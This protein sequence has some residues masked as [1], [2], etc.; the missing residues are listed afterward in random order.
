M[1]TV[2]EALAGALREAGVQTVFGLPGGENVEVLDALRR[3]GIAFVLVH[4]EPSAVF[5]ADT[6]ARL[7]GIPGVCLTTLGPG[8]MNAVA[9]V[10]H[11]YLDRAPVLV[12]TATAPE[13]VTRRHTHQIVDI[14]AVYRPITKASFTLGVKGARET[15][16]LA[17]A[18]T[19]RGRP[20]PVH[21]QVSGE[22]AAQAAEP[23]TPP[24]VGPVVGEPDTAEGMG[25]AIGEARAILRQ[26]RKPV[27]V[28]GLGLEPE[29]PYDGLRVLAESLNAPVIVTPKAKGAIPDDH[30][31]AAG[32]I[33]LTAT[34]P[35]YEILDD[36]DCVVAVAFDVVE[37]VK[38]WAH[39]APLIWIAPWANEDP[40][41]PTAVEIVGP[42][43]PVL[44]KLADGA[45]TVDR[46]WG[47]Q[48]LRIYKQ[49]LARRPL[50]TPKPGTVLP[51]TVVAVARDML[52]RDAVVTTDVGSHKIFMC[53]EWPTLAPNR[54]FVSNGLSVMGFAVPAAIAAARLSPDR[55][56]MAVTGDGGMLMAMG[57][58][59]LLRT[60]QA[61]VLI[62]VMRDDALD[63]IRSKQRRTGKPVYGT[64]FVG[65]D[66]VEA[67][68][69]FGL[70]GYR[71]RNEADLEA[72]F[73]QA[74]KAARPAV[75][76][77]FVD[78][79]GYPTTPRERTP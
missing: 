43:E 33:G 65:P 50:P 21:V 69:A 42:V 28:V 62:V 19:T 53:L 35:V 37:L 24:A 31:L 34:D 8:A 10:A 38:P 71:V 5:M 77:V 16:E 14:G 44:Y 23:G 6:T 9:G 47:A 56:V 1:P 26:A 15:V 12:V 64:E 27:I 2:A 40:R 39:D 30:P 13:H 58:L 51:Q 66:F 36:A 67:A 52:P 45:Y 32:T 22:V 70:S 57:E 11:A 18:L 68:R 55:P 4:N 29:R 72:A 74:L 76:E 73:E 78:P 49:A 3:A 75:I 59:T 46:E 60:L 7:T 63:L 25:D 17:L 61:P 79:V 41:L 20:G 48:R 54:F